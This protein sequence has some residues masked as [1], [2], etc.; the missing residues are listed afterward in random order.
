LNTDGLNH[1]I[2]TL[3][4]EPEERTECDLSFL[5]PVIKN[6]KFTNG[7]VDE[8][9]LTPED[10]K[11]ICENLKFRFYNAGEYVMHKGDQG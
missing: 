2:N 1:I 11:H 4:K 3:Q 6:A 5:M 8:K 10:F 7:D 9:P